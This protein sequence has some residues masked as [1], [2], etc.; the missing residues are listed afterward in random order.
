MF[1][2]SVETQFKAS[3]SVAL[4]NGSKE[5]EHEHF[6]AVTAEVSTD[7]LDSSGVAVDFGLLKA[8]LKEI[9][10]K[11]NGTLLNDIDVFCETGPTSEGVAMYVFHQLKPVLPEDIRLD[12]VMVSEQVG[13]SARYRQ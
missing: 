6:W 9:T 4:T 2:V 7:K 1:T 12:S 13:C 3:H 5:A 10:S 8:K 11:L